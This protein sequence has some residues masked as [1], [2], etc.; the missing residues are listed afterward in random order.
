MIPMSEVMAAG[1]LFSASYLVISSIED[2]SVSMCFKSKPY[3]SA[4]SLM[5]SP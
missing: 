5:T 4:K 1:L 2:M 3:F